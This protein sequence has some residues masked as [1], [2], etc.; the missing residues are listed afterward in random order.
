MGCVKLWDHITSLL[1][2]KVSIRETITFNKLFGRRV[3]FVEG[4]P[5]HFSKV[6]Q[7]LKNGTIK[8]I[9][10][11]SPEN[12][13]NIKCTRKEL[14]D[15]VTKVCTMAKEQGIEIIPHLHVDAK[16]NEPRAI[17]GVEER[18]LINQTVKFFKGILGGEVDKISLGFWNYTYK[19]KNLTEFVKQQGI[20]I[21]KRE[22][23]VYDWW[24]L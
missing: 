23:H 13:Q 14:T 16:F 17:P 8:R 21:A 4:P 20:Q 11:L 5:K 2:G 9:H 6:R 1:T 3:L 10:V 15:Y 12:H 22:P 7:L 18:R 19:N 24:N